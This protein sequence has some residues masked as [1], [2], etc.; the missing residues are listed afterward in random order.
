M[1]R[2]SLYNRQ[3]LDKSWKYV[4]DAEQNDTLPTIVGFSL[5][6]GLARSTIYQWDKDAE[7]TEFSDILERLRNIQ[8]VMLINKG[9]SGEYNTTI[10]HMMLIRGKHLGDRH[11][12]P[13]AIV[14][15]RDLHRALKATT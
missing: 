1:S 13:K 10:C 5:A 3:I 6:T 12:T 2:P 15:L 7:K 9:L 14:S 8:G 11:K 4:D